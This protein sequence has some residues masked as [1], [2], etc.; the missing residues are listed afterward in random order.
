[1]GRYVIKIC[2]NDKWTNDAQSDSLDAILNEY[3]DMLNVWK[4]YMEITSV[5]IVHNVTGEIVKMWERKG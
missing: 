3:E 1:M 5:M 4:S 2:E